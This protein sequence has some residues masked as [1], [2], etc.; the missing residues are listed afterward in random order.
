M[1]LTSLQLLPVNDLQE[2]AQFLR[3]FNADVSTKYIRSVEVGT[4]GK[5]TGKNLLILDSE[6]TEP[7]VPTLREF[8]VSLTEVELE[9]QTAAIQAAEKL[10]TR[11]YGNVLLGTEK[12]W[13]VLFDSE[14]TPSSL[15]AVTVSKAFLKTKAK[16]LDRGIPP[17][18]FLQELVDWGKEAPAEIFADPPPEP[19]SETDVYASVRKELGPYEDLLHRKACMLEVMRVLAGFESSWNWKEGRD[20]KNTASSSPQNE[21]EAGAW[22]VSS[23]SMVFGKDLK[24]L[25]ADK[26]KSTDAVAFQSA[27]KT[28]HPLAMEYIARLLRHTV[29]A[30]GPVLRHKINEWLSPAAVKEFQELL[31]T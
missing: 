23:N 12:K 21:V 8:P 14:A 1:P 28:N 26:V 9:A 25:V 29:R 31:T 18:S 20:V 10:V 13:V 22:Q 4:K 16:V 2:L 19:T 30:N 6:K 24:A 7:Q 27:M 5:D 15:K 3:D 11:G 17:D